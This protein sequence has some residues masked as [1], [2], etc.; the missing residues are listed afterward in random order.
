MTQK[1][2]VEKSLDRGKGF[3]F[4]HRDEEGSLT[5]SHRGKKKRGFFL[6]RSRSCEA[7]VFPKGD[8]T[9]LSNG[10]ETAIVVGLEGGG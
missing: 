8:R 6:G 1:G 4:I 3:L 7:R 9:K 2:R 5:G 10:E